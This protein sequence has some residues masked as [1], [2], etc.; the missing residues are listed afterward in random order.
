MNESKFVDALWIKELFS[1]SHAIAQPFTHFRQSDMF[2]AASFKTLQ[3]NFID[4][5]S[6]REISKPNLSDISTLRKRPSYF[7]CPE[8]IDALYCSD[9]KVFWLSFFENYS[10]SE[11]E[12]KLCLLEKFKIIGVDNNYCTDNLSIAF[13]FVT[14]T[15]PFSLEPHMDMPQKIAVGVIYVSNSGELDRGGTHLYCK[16]GETQFTENTCYDFVENSLVLIPRVS[17]SWHGGKWKG[18]GE[19][20]TLHIYFFN[21][22]KKDK[23]YLRNKFSFFL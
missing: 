4:D 21:H 5:N 22:P 9:N 14:E 18:E 17:D 16:T 2:S 7:L 10:R 20:K 12:I 6:I 8:M 23:E 3:R 19:R 13:R 11:Q 1:E 15:L